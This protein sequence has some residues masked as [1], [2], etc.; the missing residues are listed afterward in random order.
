MAFQPKKFTLKDANGV[1]HLYVVNV[2]P[3]GAL[4]RVG[5]ALA[6]SLAGPL[7]TLLDQRDM[8]E[9]IIAGE[10]RSWMDVLLEHVDMGEVAKSLSE[11]IDALDLDLILP[12]FDAVTRD[13]VPLDTETARDQ[14][15]AFNVLELIMAM[16]KVLECSGLLPFSF[17]TQSK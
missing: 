10:D 14:A 17:G 4:L 16:G 9:A 13:G 11:A 15:Y 1:E 12:L 2:L 3:S 8:I 6:A 5:K 7:L